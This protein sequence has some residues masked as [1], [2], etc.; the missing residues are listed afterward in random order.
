MIHPIYTV[1]TS[2]RIDIR[3]VLKIT[4]FHLVEGDF[5]ITF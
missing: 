3:T 4:L 5:L 2:K 1:H